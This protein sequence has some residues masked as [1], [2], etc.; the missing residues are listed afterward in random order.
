MITAI[1]PLGWFWIV[2]SMIRPLAPAM[3][4]VVPGE[5]CVPPEG[6]EWFQSLTVE[7][8]LHDRPAPTL[9]N[10]TAVPAG[11][12]DSKRTGPLRESLR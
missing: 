9:R 8:F 5:N 10:P 12:P 4:I 2:S 1:W 6:N 7:G 3:H 11:N